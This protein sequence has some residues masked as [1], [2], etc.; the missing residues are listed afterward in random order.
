MDDKGVFIFQLASGYNNALT[1]LALVSDDVITNDNAP[2]CLEY[3]EVEDFPIS[4][5][6]EPPAPP[7][8]I[9][10]FDL[11]TEEELQE[12]PTLSPPAQDTLHEA[13]FLRL[14]Y[15]YGRIS[16][17]C[18]QAMARKGILPKHLAKCL[19]SI[20]STC[21]YGQQVKKPWCTKPHKYFIPPRDTLPGE[22]VSVNMLS[23]PTL[24]YIAQLTWALTSRHYNHATVYVDIIT[25]YGYIYL[26]KS[27]SEEET[28]AGKQTFE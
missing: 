16:P 17:K 28:L 9:F 5:D 22:R 12:E 21:L 6:K 18:I 15:K 8:H 25:G 20:C 2:L 23:S 4:T 11:P 27:V 14:H 24:G 3:S 13:E 1:F 19:V 10:S 7:L 26:Q